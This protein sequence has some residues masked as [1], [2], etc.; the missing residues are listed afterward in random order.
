[1]APDLSAHRKNL[2][3]FVGTWLGA[4]EVF[5]N[6]WGPSGRLTGHWQFWLDRARVNLIHDYRE[7]RADG[8]V[9][10]AHGILTIDQPTDEYVWFWFDSY[11]FPPLSPARGQWRNS[12]VTLEKD[13]PRGRGR[14]SFTLSS[15]SLRFETASLLHGAADFTPIMHGH[16][17]RQR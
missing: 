14:S 7:E 17:L 4:G 5:T 10:E 9:F 8:T 11:G 16:Y 15:D 2:S 6:P 12:S 3:A 1:M 13:T